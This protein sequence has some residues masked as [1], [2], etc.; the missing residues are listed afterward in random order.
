MSEKSST[1]L[2]G[3]VDKIIKS[4]FR[5]EPEKAQITVKGADQLYREI[6]IDNKVTNE[7]GD[8]V[9]LKQGAHVEVK[10]EADTK[11]TTVKSNE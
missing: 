3:R 4:P 11:D 8:E 6:R 7:D 10:L 5:A 9:K 2:P 1:I